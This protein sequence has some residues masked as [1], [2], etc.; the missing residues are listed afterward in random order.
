MQRITL[1]FVITGILLYFTAA[2]V[3]AQLIEN[4]NLVG[5]GARALGM[6]GAFIAIADDATAASWNPAGLA[7]L[8]KPEGSL[9]TK[10]K[11]NK[12]S[13]EIPGFEDISWSY[14]LLSFGSAAYPLKIGERNLVGAITYQRQLEDY[15][16]W[17]Y[18]ADTSGTDFYWGNF[19][20]DESFKSELR[21]GID[22]FSPAFGI[23]VIPQLSLGATFNIWMR[24]YSLNRDFNYSFDS[25]VWDT[26]FSEWKKS[27][28]SFSGFNLLLGGL[29]EFK[30]VKMGAVLRTPLSLSKKGDYSDNTGLN[31]Y[32]DK[33]LGKIKFPFTFGFWGAVQPTENL[34]LALDFDVRPY[35]NVTFED[36]SGR[37]WTYFDYESGWTNSDTLADCNQIRLGAEY[38]FITP[39]GVLPLRAGFRTD[40]WTS[41]DSKGDQIMGKAISFGAGFVTTQFMVDGA[42]EFSSASWKYQYDTS[43]FETTG[44]SHSFILSGIFKF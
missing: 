27:E 21:G 23:Q 43:E 11:A 41:K 19:T 10:F 12:L 36:P 34:T 40:P 14:F 35:S 5:A 32:S 3:Q 16:N 42:Y 37:D 9:V 20:A 8:E 29:G 39:Q 31:N 28:Y 13:T 25:D 18:E 22:T 38:V 4:W 33:D 17:D 26:S 24:G 7:Q 6:G 44:S 2:S 1:I 30:P 15:F